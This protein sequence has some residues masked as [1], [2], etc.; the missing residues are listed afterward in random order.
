MVQEGKKNQHLPLFLVPERG[1]ILKQSKHKC[2]KKSA[3]FPFVYQ[4]CYHSSLFLA[5]TLGK[6]SRSFSIFNR[7]LSVE[8]FV[9][10]NKKKV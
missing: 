9:N 10:S 7:V 1:G 2:W 4:N 6:E 8:V 5:L 3:I